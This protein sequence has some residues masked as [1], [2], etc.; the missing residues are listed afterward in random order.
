MG[1]DNL[2]HDWQAKA[3]AFFFCGKKRIKDLLFFCKW[4]TAAVISYIKNQVAGR[5]KRH[6]YCNAFFFGRGFN[7][8]LQ[9]INKHLL[10]P[11][12]VKYDI[13]GCRVGLVFN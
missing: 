6:C 13:G 9:Q 5:G 10:K 4:Y 1:V 11:Y 12:T 8:V 3:C 7:A 2:L